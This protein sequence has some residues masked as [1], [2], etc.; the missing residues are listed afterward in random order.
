[1]LHNPKYQ[2]VRQDGVDRIDRTTFYLHNFSDTQK[3]ILPFFQAFRKRKINTNSQN[4]SSN[5]LLMLYI[6]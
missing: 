3:I 4:G 1:M 6:F 5:P 2:P